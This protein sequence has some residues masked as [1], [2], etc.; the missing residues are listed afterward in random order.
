MQP[1]Q[2]EHAD[3]PFLDTTRNDEV[4]LDEEEVF[5][6]FLFDV[7]HANGCFSFVFKSILMAV[8]D[9]EDVGRGF[10]C[11]LQVPSENSA[12]STLVK[13]SCEWKKSSL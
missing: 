7:M 10:R 13:D 8:A 5:A 12:L 3:Q 11:H 4:E 6:T 9:G 1:R 2:T